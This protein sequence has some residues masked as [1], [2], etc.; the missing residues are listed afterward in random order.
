MS[1]R[2]II[3]KILLKIKYRN[4]KF[5]KEGKNCLYRYLNSVFYSPQ[6]IELG[7]NVSIGPKADFDAAGGIKIGNG[8]I[9]APEVIIY[10]RNHNYDIDLQAL[11]F[12][13][14]CWLSSVKIED[15]VWVG[16]RCIILPGVTIGKG[17]V[18][19]AGSVVVKDVEPFAVVGGNPAKFI[20]YRDI[21]RFKQLEKEENPSVY[22]RFKH[23]KLLKKKDE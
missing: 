15:Y 14:V 8:V 11:P 17:A 13:N 21:E 22:E 3:Y 9:F 20:K 16:R 4:I 6:N 2:E 7:D 10:S 12:D 19:A 5:K 18:I 1:I 23:E